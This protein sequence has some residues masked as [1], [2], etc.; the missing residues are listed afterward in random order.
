[1]ANHALTWWYNR[2]PLSLCVCVMSGLTPPVLALT[3]RRDP[4]ANGTNGRKKEKATEDLPSEPDNGK[5]KATRNILL[6]RHS[7]YNLG[8]NGDKERILT[9]LGSWRSV[10]KHQ[11]LL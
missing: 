5:P 8:G 2:A 9:P 6:I 11:F 10:A 4:S 7:Q 3:S 1:M